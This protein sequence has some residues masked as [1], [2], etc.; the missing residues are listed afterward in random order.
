M[1]TE[2]DPNVY[3]TQAGDV[4]FFIMVYVDDLILVW[5]DQ[6]KLVQIK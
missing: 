5:N 4:K 6:N 2:V 3:V 1:K